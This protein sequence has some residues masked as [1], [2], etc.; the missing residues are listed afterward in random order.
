MTFKT[1]KISGLF[2]LECRRFEDARGTFV[3]TFHEGIFADQGISFASREEFYSSSRKGVLRGMHFQTPPAQH[4]KLVTCLS[5]AVLD[6]AVD[7]RKGSETYGQWEA[8]ELSAAN[9]LAFYIPEGLAHGFL[10][11]Q[12][13][14]LMHYAVSSV[15]SPNE[16]SGILWNSFGFEWPSGAPL[17]ST[18]DASFPALADFESP[19]A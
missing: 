18:R 15:H 12:E 6:V 3:K 14:S 2:I 1:T 4:A 10:S 11:L 19:F 13:E 5:G 8:V 17:I 16:D 9:H 7:L